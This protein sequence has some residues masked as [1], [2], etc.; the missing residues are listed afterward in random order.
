MA[1]LVR[2]SR[3]VINIFD[4]DVNRD[5]DTWLRNSKA[6]LE[7]L[8]KLSDN[9]PDGQVIGAMISFPVADG[10][11][12]YRIVSDKPLK[13]EHIPF[14]DGYQADPILIR[15]LRLSDVKQQLKASKKFRKI[16]GSQADTL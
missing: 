14:L 1:T 3:E 16:F 13:L 12:I 4:Y 15:G 8:K 9:L 2:T 11:A 10:S 7:N 6:E 5:H